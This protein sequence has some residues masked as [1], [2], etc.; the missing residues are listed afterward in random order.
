MSATGVLDVMGPAG[1][2]G[3]TNVEGTARAAGVT[4]A[5]AVPGVVGATC[6]T[7]S[8][9][10]LVSQVL[11]VPQVLQLSQMP[12]MQ[13]EAERSHEGAGF[14]VPAL[15]S[16]LGAGREGGVL[17]VFC[18]LWVV[19]CL[20]WSPTGIARPVGGW[21]PQGLETGVLSC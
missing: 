16:R 17:V 7:G 2:L 18:E 12:L 8:Q 6:V 20:E 19:S 14:G 1:V 11:W 5:T 13:G 15:T 9:V 10:L 4:G 3:A 21:M